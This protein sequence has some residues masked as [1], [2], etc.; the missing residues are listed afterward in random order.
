MSKP[1]KGS[2][3]FKRYESKQVEERLDYAD[4]VRGQIDCC[5]QASIDPEVAFPASVQALEALIAEDYR[6]EQ[7]DKE[8]N[9]STTIVEEPHWK[10]SQ[11]HDIGTLENPH[12]IDD[13]KPVRLLK[14]EDGKDLLDDDGNTMID[15][16][17]PN[18]YSPRVELVEEINWNRRFYACINQFVRMGVAIRRVPRG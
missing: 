1:I 14:G 18:I 13:T 10:T 3:R 6:D 16:S 7:Y 9:L 5:L 11:G 2:P 15:W 8:F 12:L 17:D 4:M